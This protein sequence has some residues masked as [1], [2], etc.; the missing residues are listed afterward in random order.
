M[1][2]RYD[3]ANDFRAI[4]GL[5]YQSMFR[6]DP[7]N[8]A[9]LDFGDCDEVRVPLLQDGKPRLHL[10]PDGRISQLSRKARD[11]GGIGC[12]SRADQHAPNAPAPA[13]CV[14][15]KSPA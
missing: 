13:R 12:V 5:Q 9:R 11:G 1:G 4:A 2:A 14:A 10:A 6:G 7:P 3:K 15:T 8:D